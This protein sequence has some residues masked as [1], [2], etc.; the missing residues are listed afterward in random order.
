MYYR[1]LEDLSIEPAMEEQRAER[2]M[3]VQQLLLSTINETNI[4]LS[5]VV[6][7]GDGTVSVLLLRHLCIYYRTN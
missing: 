5:S 1:L 2:S 3:F 4:P 7:S 6:G